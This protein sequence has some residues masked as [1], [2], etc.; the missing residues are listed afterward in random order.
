MSIRVL[1]D[2]LVTV[3]EVRSILAAFG[4]AHPE[5]MRVELFG[6]VAR[7]ENTPESDVDVVVSFAPGSLP[8]GMAG[9][10]FLDDLEKELA[11]RCRALWPATAASCMKLSQRQTDA[12]GTSSTTAVKPANWRDG[13]AR[14]SN[15]KVIGRRST[16]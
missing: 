8:R 15:S 13:L 1:R 2:G 7:G 9:F 5:V 14:R 11:T 16:P 4:G 3:N 12:L 10:A 6:S